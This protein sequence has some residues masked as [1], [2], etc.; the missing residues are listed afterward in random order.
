M[1][2]D[3]RMDKQCVVLCDA[4]NKIPGV[5]TTESCCGHGKQPMRI[6]LRVKTV[7]NLFILARSVN[8]MY[9]GPVNNRTEFRE[10]SVIVQDQDSGIGV[11]FLLES[12]TKGRQAY[13]QA[14]RIARNIRD[15]LGKS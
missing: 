4:I 13:R 6:W 15:S 14:N 7:Q 12:S 5:R 10:W 9:G 11:V 3:G 2:Y 8:R 1:K